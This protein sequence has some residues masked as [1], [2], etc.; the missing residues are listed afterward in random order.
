MSGRT[1]VLLLSLAALT[2]SAFPQAQSAPQTFRTTT[3]LVRLDVVVLDE[4][5]HPVTGLSAE[6]FAVTVDGKPRPLEAFAPVVLPTRDAD[7]LPTS[8]FPSVVRDIV[9]NSRT[10]D[11]RLVVVVMDRTI[12]MEAGTGVAR[13]IARAVVEALGPG[14]L[15]AIVRDTGFAND[16]RQAGFTADRARLLAVIDQPFVG[17]VNP[18]QMT[19]MGLARGEPD[20]THTGDCMCGLCVLESL[21]RVALAMGDEAR[22]Q[23]LI[24]FIGS[25]IVI[26]ERLDGTCSPLM[27]AARERVFQALDRSNVTVHSL[28]PTALQTLGRGADAF[29]FDVARSAARNLERQGSLAVFPDYT[30]GRTVLNT[31]T[32]QAAVSAI[33]DESASYYLVGV[34]RQAERDRTLRRKIRVT[35]KGHPEFDVRARTG[36]Y[37]GPSRTEAAPANLLDAA[38]GGLLPSTGLP[39]RLALTPRFR[40]AEVE[41][42]PLLGFD[43]GLLATSF[44]ALVVVLDDKARVIASQRQTMNALPGGAS[45]QLAAMALKPGHYEVRVGV[46]PR[47]SRAAASVYGDVDVPSLDARMVL[48][49]VTLQAFPRSGEVLPLDPD[50]ALTSP[51]LQRAFTP[52]ERVTAFAQVH[53]QRRDDVPVVR[54]VVQDADGRAVRAFP[55]AVDASSLRDTG[56]ADIHVE[57][58]TDDLRAG[59]YLLTI[60]ADAGGARQR[61]DILFEIH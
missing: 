29:P 52:R 27:K 54:A 10:E 31:N 43:D 16:G 35:V 46:Q 36:Y 17:L 55:V 59:A 60:T 4:R 30:G 8:A 58:P 34:P 49:G 53:V 11:G 47:G 15:A 26:Q 39:L 51:T 12:P 19:G 9:H 42:L 32:P 45:V 7:G 56:L 13:S 33:F 50:P 3:D 6:D 21:E 44:D 48:S 61:R 40:G 2:A 25:E 41:V 5:R 23:K 37:A 20:L 57:V 24:L 14:D 22:R 28:D 1:A 38:V 18:P